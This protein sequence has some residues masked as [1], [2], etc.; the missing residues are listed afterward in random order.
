M[1][2]DFRLIDSPLLVVHNRLNNILE[3]RKFV[4]GFDLLVIVHCLD[5]FDGLLNWEHIGNLKLNHRLKDVVHN[6]TGFF[7]ANNFFEEVLDSAILNDLINDL[8]LILNDIFGDI[9]FGV[10]LVICIRVEVV[11]RWVARRRAGSSLSKRHVRLEVEGLGYGSKTS[12]GELGSHDKFKLFRYFIVLSAKEVYKYSNP[13]K[14]VE[15]QHLIRAKTV[16]SGL[17]NPINN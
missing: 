16:N 10:E 9:N 13:R 14:N 7:A 4:F 6:I 5:N 8:G 12:D 11:S 2:L 1:E 3:C 15:N 17:I